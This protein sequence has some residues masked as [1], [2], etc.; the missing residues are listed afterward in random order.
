MTPADGLDDA[1]QDD[2]SAVP[3]CAGADDTA[4]TPR[5]PIVGLGASAGGLEALEQFLKALPA[6]TGMA[7]VIVQHLD[8]SHPSILAAILQRSTAM[9]VLEVKDQMPVERDHVYVIPPNR[10]M[11]IFRG[12]L[13]LSE[14]A[15]P[16]HQRLPIDAFFRS[17]ALDQGDRASGIILSGNGSDGTLGLREILG[18]GG[19]CLVQDPASARYGGM[20]ASAIA[21]GH[22]DHVLPVEQMP[23]ALREAY[24]GSTRNLHAAPAMPLAGFNRIL[25]LLRSGTGH[26]FSQYKVST[27]SRRIERRMAQHGIDDPEV[28]VRHLKQNPAEMQTLFREMLINVTSFFRDPQAFAALSHVALPPLLAAKADGDPFRVW[29]AGCATGE[30]AYSI[31]IVL[32]ELAERL[33]RDLRIQIYSTDLDD[34]AIAAA[35]TGLYSSNIGQDLSAEQLQRYFTRD[36]AGYR[37]KKEI[38]DM[39]VF[40]VQSVTRD[41]PFTRLDLL[42]CRNLMIYLQPELQDRLIQTFHY[43]LN[44]G[45]V[46]ML[47]PSESIAGHA[48][49]FE[50]INRKWKIY[51]SL[52]TSG[53]VRS[54][55]GGE[56]ALPAIGVAE[57]LPQA[58]R[59]PR[60]VQVA[61]LARRAL[62]QAFAPPSVVTDMQGNLL[63]VQG[64]T[65]RFLRPAPGKPTHC[66]VDMAFDGLQLELR[67]ALVQA[68]HGV[69][70][71]DRPLRFQRDGQMHQVA[72]S[73]RPL[74]DAA[75]PIKMLLISFQDLPEPAPDQQPERAAVRKPRGRISAQAQAMLDLERELASAKESMNA[76]LEEQQVSNEELKSANEELQSTNEELQST[77]EEMETSKEELQSVN[78]ELVTVNAELQ[79]K[80]EQMA[81]M[82]DDMKNLLDNIR[83]G[84]IFLDRHL[85]IRRFTRDAT[86]VYRLV[87]TDIGRALADIRSDL[88]GDDLLVD[89]RRVL[90]TLVPIEREV[91]TPAG[92]WYLA[93]I[94]PYRTVD[95]LIDGVVLT[96]SDVTERVEAI[97]SRKA[98]G[99]A[100]AIVDAM[101]EPLLVLDASLQ[102][103]SA[104]QAFYREFGRAAADTVG[105][106][107]FQIGAAEWDTPMLHELLETR[108]PRD[109]RLLGETARL[110]FPAS[111]P[112]RI[113]LTAQRIAESGADFLLLLVCGIESDAGEGCM[114]D[115]PP[116]RAAPPEEAL[117]L[118]VG[119]GAGKQVEMPAAAHAELVPGSN[120][121]PSQPS[122]A[123]RPVTTARPSPMVDV[124]DTVAGLRNVGG[125]HP[126]YLNVLR[127]FSQLYGDRA[128]ELEQ[129][130]AAGDLPGM[131]RTAHSIKGSSATIGADRL[132]SL[133]RAIEL[134]S[135]EDMPAA[136]R[137]MLDELATV[138][139]AIRTGH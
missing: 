104:N 128:H 131:R 15:E 42:V 7:F 51:R 47:S 75:I 96:L 10:D 91:C 89:A 33:Q 118:P 130:G 56:L 32:R 65:G 125:R 112:R 62:L 16:R 81:G 18:A 44:P 110:A 88:P 109:G 50:P 134:A 129:V 120:P 13:Q 46:L 3:F 132:A 26:D 6:G 19:L 107:V 79:I 97:A 53:S 23:A 29:V 41:P 76:L 103:L 122:P 34:E 137:S 77:N 119:V 43:A 30:E 2:S 40:A 73:V 31:A 113:R 61:E 39:V 116:Q 17:L 135:D 71:R 90:E 98:R 66:V 36:D 57:A 25:M 35:R 136:W 139:A 49:L 123:E 1:P 64:E 8:P 100:E 37:V 84:T 60:E 124:I 48:E 38:R 74:A 72:L 80:I 105:R 82:Q 114:T 27:V 106:K 78:E 85:K 14:P 101:P 59:R 28:Y 111:A 121:V 11:V 52:A 99:L 54:L 12:T 86:R 115:E 4:D 9:P 20:P 102:V 138:V 21:A 133:A 92:L 95:D 70:W 22:V 58:G 55:P 69:E 108:L 94:Q 68:A 93:R 45:G 63:H 83:V 87:E 127:H 117:D 24:Y 5:F 67:A 126:L